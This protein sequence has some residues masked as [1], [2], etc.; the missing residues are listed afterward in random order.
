M[1]RARFPSKISRFSSRLRVKEQADFT[2]VADLAAAFK[3][4]RLG[5]APTP[6]RVAPPP[7]SGLELRTLGRACQLDEEALAA[8]QVAVPATVIPL[9]PA[10]G[11]PLSDGLLCTWP[12]ASFFFWRSFV[13]WCCVCPHWC[14]AWA[15][16]ELCGLPWASPPCCPLYSSA[17]PLASRLRSSSPWCLPLPS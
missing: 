17:S 3:A 10:D 15:L 6:A 12:R 4:R 9:P 14:V 16:Y 2:K 5:A 8:V 11:S 1:K 13:F 7:L